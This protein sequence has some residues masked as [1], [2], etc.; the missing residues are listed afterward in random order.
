MTSI[1]ETI[2][3]ALPAD[4]RSYQH[5]V[6]EV[7]VAL[8]EREYTLSDQIT[9]AVVQHFGVSEGEVRHELEGIGMAVRPAPEPEP[10]A[11]AEP[12]ADEAPAKK[13]KKA[14]KDR[15]GKLEASV[16]RLTELAER[17]LGARA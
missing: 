8:T 17:H 5:E 6:G 14:K 4:A 7:T 12:V 11:V 1:N 16:A 2:N 3:A 9:T 10:V 13:G 15:I